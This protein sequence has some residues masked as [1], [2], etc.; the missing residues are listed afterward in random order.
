MFR[1]G[2]KIQLQIAKRGNGLAICIPSDVAQTLG[3]K[4]GDIA[5]GS[6]ITDCGLTIRL[7][8]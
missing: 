8:I 4:E 6:L 2:K 1:R 5:E 3:F 7:N